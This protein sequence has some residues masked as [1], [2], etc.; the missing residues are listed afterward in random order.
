MAL[1]NSS[2]Y[3]NL[4]S[5]S[6][7]RNSR[8]AGKFKIVYLT[9]KSRVNEEIGKI[10]VVDKYEENKPIFLLN[11]QDSIRFI[12]M[13]MKQVRSLTG[14]VNNQDKNICFSFNA[15]EGSISSSGNPCPSG[16]DRKKIPF[17]YNCK[18]QWIFGGAL[19][20]DKNK[21]IKVKNET[22]GELETV[23]IY[24]KNAGMKYVSVMKFFD[25]IE[26]KATTLPP[27][28]DDPEYEMKFVA[29]RRFIIEV[30]KGVEVSQN[31]G[32]I[33]VFKYT[34][35]LKLP[36][37][38]VVK[39]MKQSDK[40][41]NDFTEQFDISKYL[42]KSNNTTTSAPAA[43]IPFENDTPATSVPTESSQEQKTNIP[44]VSSEELSSE[45]DLGF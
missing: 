12:L 5:F 23:L 24:F 8:K 15:E 16:P 31:Y 3:K 13:Y 32:D 39:I 9:G 30:T 45:I 11:N 18:F 44:E 29:P 37:E 14:K 28:S 42:N 40:Y 33:S 4:G 19:L 38:Q 41:I 6:Y 2:D 26:E 17:C 22:T 7:E 27:L 25:A 10:Q 43:G 34:P 20:D 35:I 36:D 1:I 21:P